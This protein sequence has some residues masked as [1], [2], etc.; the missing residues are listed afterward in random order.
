MN[1]N[2]KQTPIVLPKLKHGEGSITYDYKHNVYVYRKMSHGERLTVKAKTMP[3]VFSQMKEKEQ[4]KETNRK[5]FSFTSASTLSESMAKWL[6]EYKKN[7]VK[8]RSYDRIFKTFENQI[9]PYHISKVQ[10]HAIDDLMIMQHFNELIQR[11]YSYSVISKTYDLFSQYFRY[12]YRQNPFNNPMCLYKKPSSDSME[13]TEKKIQIL[14]NQQM[15]CLREEALKK[16]PN[17]TNVFWWGHLVVILMYTGMRIGEALALKWSDI[18]FLAGTI[19]IDKSRSEIIDWAQNPDRY[20]HAYILSYTSPKTK[21]SFRTIYMIN[22]VKEC[23]NEVKLKNK[24]AS[25]DDYVFLTRTGNVPARMS[26]LYR[27]LRTMFNNCG[28]DLT[29]DGFH[30]LRHTFISALC[31]QKVDKKVIA[32]IVGH[33]STDMIEKIYQHVL[34]EEK[35]DAMKAIEVL[36]LLTS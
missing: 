19:H 24:S 10:V 32:T 31:R 2:S 18:N 35:I 11:K 5:L 26:T 3:E 9:L 27:S 21:S 34:V 12:I 7:S 22:I 16:Y 28:F 20:K 1:N 15:R 23:L 29:S 6:Q 30:V 8:P 36:D 13:I 4:H 17:G 25:Q 14:D 33:S